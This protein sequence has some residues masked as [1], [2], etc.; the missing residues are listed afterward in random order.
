M[1]AFNGN[2][3]EAALVRELAVQ[4][5]ATVS[6]YFTYH[7]QLKEL[8]RALGGSPAPLDS[9]YVT[10]KKILLTQGGSNTFTPREWKQVYD[11]CGISGSPRDV[12]FTQ[13]KLIQGLVD[14]GG[15]G[16]GSPTPPTPPGPTPVP[17]T[18][19]WAES[20][21]TGAEW[22]SL[23]PDGSDGFTGTSDGDSVAVLPQDIA[24]EIND[25]ETTVTFNVDTLTAGTLEFS[26]DADGSLS[27]DSIDSGTITS[28]SGG[29]KSGARVLITD[30]GE[31]IV[32]IR[33]KT[34]A[35]RK[36][37]AKFKLNENAAQVVVSGFAAEVTGVYADENTQTGDY[38]SAVAGEGG[39]VNGAVQEAIDSAF[40]DWVDVSH[41]DP[42]AIDKFNHFWLPATEDINGANVAL[43]YNVGAQVLT[44]I[45]AGTPTYTPAG[46]YTFDGAMGLRVVGL[47]ETAVR[48]SPNGNYHTIWNYLISKA[49]VGEGYMYVNNA[50]NDS[51]LTDSAGSIVYSWSQGNGNVRAY[52]TLP[53]LIEVGNSRDYAGQ[54]YYHWRFN[55]VVVGTGGAFNSFHVASSVTDYIYGGRNELTP[56][57]YGPWTCGAFGVGGELYHSSNSTSNAIYDR[58]Q[59]RIYVGIRNILDSLG[60]A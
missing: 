12:Q 8:L 42:A 20:D 10:W 14:A 5:G 29:T 13:A 19:D 16:G 1:V 51:A 25:K 39:T 6:P 54:N 32:V 49:P 46:G 11:I 40:T 59:Q 17:L 44:Q 43:V 31:K 50:K 28:V 33:H 18:S 53:S 60:R 26:I 48:A 4:A 35:L 34:S 56:Q 27:G 24:P 36:L 38:L 55:G 7:A 58:I 15:I 2:L 45:G 57:Y 47:N 52:P 23:T 21:T 41:G 37:K 3:T 9:Q 22:T 30:T